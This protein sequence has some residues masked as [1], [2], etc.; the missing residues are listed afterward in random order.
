MKLPSQ[1]ESSVPLIVLSHLRWGF[2]FQRPQHLLSR[3]ASR[4]PVIFVEEPVFTP[5]PPHLKFHTPCPGVTVVVPHTPVAHAGF[6]DDQLPVL[7]PLLRAY[8]ASHHI[9]H[10]ICWLYTPMALPLVDALTP[11]CVVYDCMDELAAFLHAPAQLIQRERMLFDRADVVFTG[12]PSL[13][14]AKRSLHQNIH[15]IPSSVDAAHFA[16]QRVNADSAEA[17]NACQLQGA[18]SHPRLGFFGVIDERLDLDL[19]GAIASA[20]PEWQIVMVG[21]VVKIDPGMLPSM[22]NIHWL[23]MQT[24]ELLP[25]LLAGWDI[26]LVP[27]AR[28]AS[29][30]F[31]S[32]TKTLEYMAGEKPVVS[33]AI[34][35]VKALYG[36]AV[37]IAETSD[38]FIRACEDLLS[39]SDDCRRERLQQMRSTV[40]SCSWDHS[41][42]SVRTL[43]EAAWQQ[44][45]PAALDVMPGAGSVLAP[46]LVLQ[47]QFGSILD[48][49]PNAK[50]A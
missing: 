5:D 22:H 38:A 25:H 8:V 45:Q 4:W 35:D 36:Q 2:V 15:C 30:R 27:F 23:G 47:A 21:P 32:P 42:N 18:L 33:T 39:E 3:L 50:R 46:E 34:H 28:N 1:A 40:A 24:Y 10:A 20:H 19:I 7:E 16:P 17:R 37:E 48:A 26:C 13:Y 12:G 29:T 6:H 41:A 11:R 31:I 14:E 43:I 9:E 44:A 49:E